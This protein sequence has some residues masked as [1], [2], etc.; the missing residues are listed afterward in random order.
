MTSN[1][2]NHA[3]LPHLSVFCIFT[4]RFLLFD[5]GMLLLSG[6]REVEELYGYIYERATGRPS[7]LLSTSSLLIFPEEASRRIVI[8]IY[9]VMGWKMHMEKSGVTL[10]FSLFYSKFCLVGDNHT[11]LLFPFLSWHVCC[12]PSSDNKISNLTKEGYLYLDFLKLVVSSAI[13]KCGQ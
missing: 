5:S 6:Q 1:L 10:Y 13:N 3:S 2:P 7:R 8:H 11:L 9:R 4:S 12:P